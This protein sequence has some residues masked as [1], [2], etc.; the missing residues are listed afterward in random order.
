MSERMLDILHRKTSCEPP[1]PRS[2]EHGDHDRATHNMNYHAVVVFHKDSENRPCRPVLSI[3]HLSSKPDR[4]R[5]EIVSNPRGLEILKAC[6]LC[7]EPTN[8]PHD[9]AT[10]MTNLLTVTAVSI[11]DDEA[12][13]MINNIA[14]INTWVSHSRI[15]LTERSNFPRIPVSMHKYIPTSKGSV[16]EIETASTSTDVALA[17]LAMREGLNQSRSLYSLLERLHTYVSTPENFYDAISLY[18]RPL[19]LT[20]FRSNAF[21]YITTTT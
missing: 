15:R 16:K 8:S 12:V 1:T 3:I 5:D 2:G 11:T 9:F 6:Q 20:S 7:D 17:V 10:D 21:R 4:L 13:A 19:D 18:S 14:R